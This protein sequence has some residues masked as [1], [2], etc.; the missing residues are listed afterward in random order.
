MSTV[1]RIAPFLIWWSYSIGRAIVATPEHGFWALRDA[2]QALESCFVIVG[3]N[4]AREPEDVERLF[5]WL[6]RLLVVACIYG[7]IGNQFRDQLKAISPVLTGGSGEPVTLIG[8]MNTTDVL[9]LCAAVYLLIMAREGK[10]TL[11]PVL[12]ASAIVCYTVLVFQNRTIYLGLFAILGVMGLFRAKLVGR[13]LAMVPVFIAAVLIISAL[14]LKVSGRLSQE[15]S[16]SFFAEHIAA[17]FGIADRSNAAIADAASGVDERLTWWTNIF[18]QLT[19]DPVTFLIGLGY[20]FPLIPFTA[21]GGIVAREPHNSLISVF[22]RGGLIGLSCWLWFQLELFTCW[23]RYFSAQAKR[24]GSRQWENRLLVLLSFLVLVMVGAI[25]EDNM[26]KP[27]FAIP[28]YF[29]WGVLLRKATSLGGALRSRR[30]PSLGS[31]R[32]ISGPAAAARDP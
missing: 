30:P 2:S 22:A 16:L 32:G 17:V 24:R 10:P 5:R 11:R 4:F 12:V 27:F 1:V 18:H 13:I 20:G 25:G 23:L 14:G 26:E 21:N 9:M 29:F 6:P 19:A 15:V 28:Y 31:S 7:V 8:I 3:F